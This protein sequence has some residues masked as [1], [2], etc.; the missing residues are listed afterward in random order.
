MRNFNKD[1]DRVLSNLQ[2]CNQILHNCNNEM[3]MALSG[4]KTI[5]YA[6]TDLNNTQ[7]FNSDFEIFMTDIGGATFYRTKTLAK[8]IMEEFE[9]DE[10]DF[11]IIT[12]SL[13][14]VE[15]D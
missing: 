11:K 10:K 5:R 1:I 13:K 3:R 4:A 9:L 14:V 7:Y 12:V 2:E 6:I 15:N 8:A